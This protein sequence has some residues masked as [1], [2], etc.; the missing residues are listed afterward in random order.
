MDADFCISLV[1]MI[2]GTK[3]FSDSRT[4]QPQGGGG[5]KK[6]KHMKNMKLWPLSPYHKRSDSKIWLSE[7]FFRALTSKL[8]NK[9][10]HA[11]KTYRNGA[12]LNYIYTPMVL[13]K[14]FWLIHLKESHVKFTG[15]KKSAIPCEQNYTAWLANNDK[16]VFR[17]LTWKISLSVSGEQALRL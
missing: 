6:K 3:Q 17:K 16:T 1:Y 7:S 11:A 5:G 9:K 2:S 15:K 10:I 8:W 12:K 13:L 14:L 4:F